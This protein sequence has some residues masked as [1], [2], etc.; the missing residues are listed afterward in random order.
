MC[1]GVSPCRIGS[2]I[3]FLE[4]LNHPAG[5]K[6]VHFWAPA[7]KWGLVIAGLADMKRP[8]EQISLAQTACTIF[9]KVD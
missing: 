5:P 7:M 2:M 4:F 1:V 3:K 6:T 9:D 8:V